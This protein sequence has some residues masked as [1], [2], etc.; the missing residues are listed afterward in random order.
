[1]QK[2]KKKKKAPNNICY[3]YTHNIVPICRR[4]DYII[5]LVTPVIGPNKSKKLAWLI[6]LAQNIR[7]KVIVCEAM[8]VVFHS[9]LPRILCAGAISRASF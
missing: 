8:C 4:S 6:A 9:T 3:N 7:G 2:K 5:G 1:M